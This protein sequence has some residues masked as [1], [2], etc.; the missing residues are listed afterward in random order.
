MSPFSFIILLIWIR[1]LCPLISLIKE[2]FIWLIFFKELDPGIG[3]SLYSSLC[4]LLIG[5]SPQF[6][7]SC[8][9]L[10]LG[11]FASFSSRDFNEL[12]RC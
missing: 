9:L 6:D 8:H 12:L 4:Y 2:L 5:F 10:L 1:S 3:D 11:V 7:F